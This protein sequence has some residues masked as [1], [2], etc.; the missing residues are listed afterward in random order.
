MSTKDSLNVVLGT[1]PVGRTLAEHLAAEGR[2]V[3]V[4]NRAGKA[5]V[6][7]G[8][9]VTAADVSDLEQARHACKDAGV[10][11]GCG[12]LGYGNWPEVW[13]PLMKGMLAGAE[14]AGARFV[15]MDNLY[16]YGPTEKT[17]TEDLPLTDYGKKP[18]TRAA[19]TRLWQEAHA[20]GRVQAA[21][22]RASDFYGPGVT[23]AALGEYTFGAIT[24]GRAAQCFGDVDLLHTYTYV[25][26]VVR[27]LVTVA[28]ADDESFGQAWHVPNA[29]DRSTR[30]LL[31][32]FAD[33]V[34]QPL[35]VK[36]LPGWLHTVL[37][38]FISDL[39]ELKEM[40][41]EWNRPYRVDHG[42]FGSRFWNDPTSFEDGIR[43]T[44]DWY[45]AR[46]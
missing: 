28:D 35:K 44:A 7:A 31:Q 8:V 20:A 19:I 24:K 14:A 37:G 18:A 26:D 13:P 30:E 11:F 12:G 34:G 5:A 45:Q 4:A 46:S 33:A 16:M 1:G 2:R 15:F 36:T 3:R 21:A 27:A 32:L 25:P 6:P 17:L 42:K 39:R 38:V 40:M 41:Y 22:V 23:M 10:V 29:P 43:A 9:E